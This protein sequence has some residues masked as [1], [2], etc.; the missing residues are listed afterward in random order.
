MANFGHSTGFGAPARPEARTVTYNADTLTAA[1]SRSAAMGARVISVTLGT[2]AVLLALVALTM[3]WAFT[4]SLAVSWG[5]VVKLGLIGSAIVAALSGLPVA[6]AM[7]SRSYP[8]EARQCMRV[9]LVALLVV[10]V[11][12]VAFA[13]RLEVPRMLDKTVRTVAAPLA[14]PIVRSRWMT[15]QI[16]AATDGCARMRND[17]DGMVCEEFRWRLGQTGAV[18]APRGVVAEAAPSDWSPAATLGI[19]SLADGV[20]RQMIVLL[21]SLIAAG[22]SGVLGRW[23]TLATAESYRL[24]EGMASALPSMPQMPAAPASSAGPV[25][26]QQD[27]F[28]MWASGRLIQESGAS[29]RADA[30]LAD[31]QETCRLNN[32]PLQTSNWFFNKMA[33]LARSSGGRIVKYKSDTMHFRGVRLPSSG[34]MNAGVANGGNQW[35]N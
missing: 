4:S 25:V 14:P 27:A 15:P 34:D 19:T 18:Q 13:G 20:A 12:A 9:W 16:W 22:G 10:G 23:A 28:S 1:Q 32:L 26:M 5:E 11:A 7:L 3:S 31:F 24:G 17:Y 6:A 2:A 8:G 29:V 35:V 30:L 33:D 21:L